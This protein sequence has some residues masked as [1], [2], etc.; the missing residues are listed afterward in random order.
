MKNSISLRYLLTLIMALFFVGI[1]CQAVQAENLDEIRKYEITADVNDD[2]TVNL[3]YHIE[4]EVL[5]SESEGPLEW[6]KIG[7]PNSNVEDYEALSDNISD[8]E[9]YDDGGSYMRI[10]FDQEYE[11][12]DIVK[13]D[14]SIVQNNMYQM[15]LNE[16]GFTVYT[17]TPGWF[18]EIVVDSMVIRWKA[19]QVK[20]WSPA[21][22]VDNGYN[23]WE[24][25]L[26]EG[27]KFTVTLTYPNEAFAFD[28]EVSDRY[29]ESEWDDEWDESW[30]EE[31]WDDDDDAGSLVLGG[32]VWIIFIA[33]SII[34]RAMQSNN[35]YDRGAG[36]GDRT[37]TKV[38]RTKI[39]YHTNCPNCGAPRA[40]GKDACEYCGTN[41]IKSEEILKEET[42]T[43]EEKKKYTGNRDYAYGGVPDTFIRVHTVHVPVT[44]THSSH[45]TRGGGCAHSS[46]ACACASCAC[47]CACACAGGGR[48]GCSNK[49]FYK[50]ALKLRMLEKRSRK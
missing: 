32:A 16:E 39:T 4:W 5:D 30:D 21:C 3:K 20:D 22:L 18:S 8:I 38:T 7:I 40:E 19:D 42:L 37:E 48:A 27:E 2:A 23:T 49:D 31:F 36:F 26:D 45:G 29:E 12:G 1:I 11:E 33:V 9:Y 35:Q 15:N 14:F 6:V 47:A 28:S 13:F 43:K 25:S 44:H 17:F 46:C 50:K 24:T 41:L 10:D 34:A